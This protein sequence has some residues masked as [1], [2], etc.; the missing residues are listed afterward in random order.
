MLGLPARKS[1]ILN[2]IVRE[3]IR[4]AVPVA[5]ESVARS[6]NLKVSPATVRNEVAELEDEGYLTRPHSSAGSVPLEKGYRTYV[7]SVALV[8]TLEF[9]RSVRASV[10]ARLE[11]AEQELLALLGLVGLTVETLD[12]VVERE[13]RLISRSFIARRELAEV[14]STLKRLGTEA[15]SIRTGIYRYLNRRGIGPG[16]GKADS[17]TLAAGLASLDDAARR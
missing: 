10:R 12:E 2:R 17:E 5:S 11:E 4:A 3:Y 15:E 7:E 1:K 8:Q 16:G 14:K 13:L 6:S 9:P